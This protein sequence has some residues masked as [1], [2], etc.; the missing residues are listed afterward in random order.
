MTTENV[1]TT[2]KD[3]SG[4]GVAS[5]V[6]GILSICPSA[7]IWP[8]AGL[9]GLAGLILGFLG[10]KSTKKGMAT[11]GI[12]LSALALL[13][14]VVAIVLTAIGAS[15]GFMDQWQQYLNQLNY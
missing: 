8:C 3:K 7:I 11:A 2:V 12:I 13:W 15:S 4:L 5:L 9:M 14:T 10:L 1:P 6:L